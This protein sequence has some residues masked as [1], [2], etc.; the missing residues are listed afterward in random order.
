MRSVSRE[1]IETVILALL[2]FLALQFSLQ[3]FRVEGISMSPT[4]EGGQYVLVNKA[5]YVHFRDSWLT[6]MVPFI[7][8]TKEGSSYPFHP[9]N[10]G[11]VI[12][13]RAPPDPTRDFVKRVIGV[14]GD[15]VSIVAGE[16]SVNGKRLEE[17]Y[18][19]N[20]DSYNMRPLTVPPDSY[21]VLGD[22]RRAS[23]DS[24]QWGF[25]PTANIIGKAWLAYW[26]PDQWAVVQ[27]FHK[28]TP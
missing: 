13:F 14:P 17:P 6:R 22:N 28:A 19:Y 11:D 15:T 18:V 20:K 7:K 8:S 23:D 12:V 3:N 9:P 1:I 16:V 2:L 21:F 27:G 24:R 4:L 10:K 25:V 5:L 26:P